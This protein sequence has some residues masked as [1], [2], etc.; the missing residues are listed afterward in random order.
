MEVGNFRFDKGAH[1]GHA[2]KHPYPTIR[3]LF[4]VRK[5]DYA[6]FFASSF[7]ARLMADRTPLMEAMEML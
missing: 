7:L 4:Y 5:V 6:P 1:N 2:K 3:M